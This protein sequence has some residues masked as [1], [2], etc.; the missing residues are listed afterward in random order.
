MLWYIKVKVD[1]DG[2]EFLFLKD[3]RTTHHPMLHAAA[4][5]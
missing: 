4:M 2:S 5:M 3:T 1:A